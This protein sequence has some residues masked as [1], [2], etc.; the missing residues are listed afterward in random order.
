MTKKSNLPAQGCYN[1]LMPRFLFALALLTVSAVP[2]LAQDVLKTLG[3][4]ISASQ[5]PAAEIVTPPKGD[6]AE[7]ETQTV[8]AKI[9]KVI[10]P[11]T[12]LADGGT[13]YRLSGIDIPESGEVAV[14]A[15]AHLKGLLEGQDVR[16]H[17]SRNESAGRTTR[18]GQTLAVLERR[19]DHLWAQ[20]SLVVNGLA[21]VRTTPAN[22]EMARQL[23]A[24]E[25]AAR[26]AK[27]GL[28]TDAQFA[29]L[30][31]E[32]ALTR[33][34]SF[35]IVEGDVFS[36]SQLNA[37]TFLNF[38]NDWKKDF[39]VG[40]PADLRRDLSRRSINFQSLGHKRVRVRGWLEDRN[41]PFI[42]LDH[43]Q[44]IEVMDKAFAILQDPVKPSARG[45]KGP[46]AP[47]IEKPV[48]ETPEVEAPKAPA[49]PKA[50]MNE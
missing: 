1:Y 33:K 19:R 43:A 21:R 8:A 25:T 34:N 32:Q 13:I 41:G 29:V 26:E 16:V 37:E 20:G 46:Q 38:S 30:T 35:Q 14:Q 39:S 27:R 48:V 6:F 24:L 23:L 2:A 44:Q 22:P 12:L 5:K 49:V 36:V 45:F 9:Q 11:Y 47:G 17:L 18:L 3:D 31:P 4:A 7:L 28:W 10:D 50:K 40:I 15:M 42:T